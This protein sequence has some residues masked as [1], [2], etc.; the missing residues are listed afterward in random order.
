MS[1]KVARSLFETI[2]PAQM[3]AY[4]IS[5][6]NNLLNS[7]IIGN[8]M[9]SEYLAVFGFISPLTF[10]LS[11]ISGGISAGAQIL[12]GRYMGSGE[13][14][15]V[16]A[17]Y[18]VVSVLCLLFGSLFASV[19]VCF[20][21]Q[22]S[23][24]LG[25][26]EGTAL[27]Y[28]TAYLR[29]YGLGMPFILF[30]MAIIPFLQLNNAGSV[31]MFSVAAV[32]SVN[33]IGNLLN[34]FVFRGGMLGCGFSNTA[35]YFT[36]VIV[37]VVFFLSGKCK[38]RL[39]VKSLGFGYAKSIF[40]LGLPAFIMPLTITLRNLVINNVAVRSAGTKALTALAVIDNV[41]ALAGVFVNGV[42]AACSMSAS[43]FF[44]ERDTKSLRDLYPLS[45]K[46][47]YLFGGVLY[48][49]IFVFAKP[50]ALLFGAE[51]EIAVFVAV[52][53]RIV[54]GYLLTNVFF[55]ILSEM[56][57]GMGNTFILS[58]IQPVVMTVASG[59][60]C[61]GLEKIG[62]IY[63]MWH[64]FLLGEPIAFAAMAFYVRK[65]QGR[66]PR[67]LTDMIVIPD[68]AGADEDQRLT[69]VIRNKQDV[70]DASDKVIKFLSKRNAS[71]KTAFYSGLCVEELAIA[72]LD[73][74][75]DLPEK[76]RR[77]KEIDLRL[78][79]EEDGISIML[80]DNFPRFDPVEWMKLHEPDDPI[81]YLGIR[82]VTKM[83][84]SAEYNSTLNLN[85]I[86]LKLGN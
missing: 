72:I 83:A 41:C 36:S 18:S 77:G 3:L 39:S 4:A 10:V 46:Y 12:C 16:G 47:D 1:N 81:R 75:A 5:C 2:L 27:E 53:I 70:S 74:A 69:S 33:L 34:I 19:Y 60:L 67:K 84:T 73:H 11:M 80:R 7:L 14:D 56:Y 55:V 45:L 28:T 52:T 15:N 44:G 31:M 32:A 66:F 76:K 30:S 50:L 20:A 79:C 26:T 65:K 82:M 38:V 25:A 85:V 62:G 64:V 71:E 49:L 21:P 23:A 58:V 86:A 78:I 57:K 42:A 29:S 48:A 37:V 24:I 9:G 40:K 8:L 54:L 61:F 6:I 13:I 17:T 68:N 63:G 22:L 35:A 51:P 43:I 59:L